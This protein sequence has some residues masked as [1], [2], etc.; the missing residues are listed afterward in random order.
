MFGCYRVV[1]FDAI[2]IPSV[3]ILLFQLPEG[4][5]VHETEDHLQNVADEPVSNHINTRVSDFFKQTFRMIS[6]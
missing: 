4:T 3:I 1:R 6:R 2:I 5:L